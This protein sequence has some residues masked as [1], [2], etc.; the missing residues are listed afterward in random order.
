MKIGLAFRL[1]RFRLVSSRDLKKGLLFAV[2]SALASPS[3]T[4]NQVTG[5]EVQSLAAS[6]RF[7]NHVQAGRDA[8]LPHSLAFVRVCRDL[9][10]PAQL[11]LGVTAQPFSAHAWVQLGDTVLNDSIERVSEFA[12]IAAF[13]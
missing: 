11:V 1:V 7:L 2:N 4:R 10:T 12:P 8:C 5:A 13:S 6:D 9:G 3:G